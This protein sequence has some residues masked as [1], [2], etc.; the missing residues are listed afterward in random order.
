MSHMFRVRPRSLEPDIEVREIAKRLKDHSMEERK[1][2]NVQ[3]A[4]K[5]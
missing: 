1:P 3:V 2:Q 4:P 5:V